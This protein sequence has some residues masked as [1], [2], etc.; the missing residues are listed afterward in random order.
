MY[1]LPGARYIVLCEGVCDEAKKACSII[2]G[3]LKQQLIR[4][5]C[6]LDT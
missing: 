2:V 6:S 4:N 5:N 3:W 1:L